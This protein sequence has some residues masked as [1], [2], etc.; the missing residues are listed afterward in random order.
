[1]IDPMTESS[2]GLDGQITRLL[3]NTIPSTVNRT[4]ENIILPNPLSYREKSPA[5]IS[6]RS[7]RP[8]RPLDISSSDDTVFSLPPPENRSLSGNRMIRTPAENKSLSSDQIIPSQTPD[9]PY[10][11]VVVP[12]SAPQPEN[13]FA[14]TD[15]SI[16]SEKPIAMDSSVSGDVEK[17]TEVISDLERTF[18]IRPDSFERLATEAQS[19]SKSVAEAPSSH[20]PLNGEPVPRLNAVQQLK[21]EPTDPKLSTTPSRNRED[22]MLVPTLRPMTSIQPGTLLTPR[23]ER[24]EQQL[25]IGRLKIEVVTS[26]DMTAQQTNTHPTRRA[27]RQQPRHEENCYRSKLRFGLGQL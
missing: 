7:N 8:S 27:V 24:K 18:P 22:D 13:R 1:V 16:V 23:A 12:I 2:S 9:Y 6:D 10:R 11:D 26:P 3:E 4:S 25:V 19:R 17:S 15:S 20:K 5:N 14:N 21:F